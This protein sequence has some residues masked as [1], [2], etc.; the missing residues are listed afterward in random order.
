MEPSH[1]PE[2]HEIIE[3]SIADEKFETVLDAIA[4]SIDERKGEAPKTEF[5]IESIEV[6]IDDFKEAHTDE[7][8]LLCS[9]QGYT[10]LFDT[11]PICLGDGVR[12]EDDPGS[13]CLEDFKPIDFQL[14]D[15][16]R[17]KNNRLCPECGGKQQ[18]PRGWVE[19]HDYA[20]M[21]DNHTSRST[22]DNKA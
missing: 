6:D 21:I 22:T 18:V 2:V 19:Y 9:G 11:C 4:K 7:L 3:K 15:G 10:L 12:P 20:G 16:T 1:H 5:I 14:S 17:S 8:C 13:T